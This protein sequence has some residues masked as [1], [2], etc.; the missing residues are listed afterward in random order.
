MRQI[1]RTLLT[2]VFIL[3]LGVMTIASIYLALEKKRVSE[4][5]AKDR[6]LWG[7]KNKTLKES[8]NK[9]EEGINKL[10]EELEKIT[11]DLHNANEELHNLKLGYEDLKKENASLNQKISQYSRE[12]EGLLAKV[13]QLETS[14]KSAEEARKTKEA[15]EEFWTRILR[16]KAELELRA[17]ELEE[18]LRNNRALLTRLE[19]E[20][21]GLGLR[22]NAVQQEKMN[23]EKTLGDE[24]TL[25]PASPRDTLRVR[26]DK[27]NME[28]QL[29]DLAVEKDAL[30]MRINTLRT[31]IDKT[32]SEKQRLN[33]QIEKVNEWLE[34]KLGEVN[35]VRQELETALKEAKRIALS[36]SA[37]TVQLAPIVVKKED[38][39][40]HASGKEKAEI[41]PTT[42]KIMPPQTREAAVVLVNEAHNF[43]I[44]NIGKKEGVLE[45][46]VFDIFENKQKIARVK[47]KEVRERLSA[48][49]IL[50]VVKDKKIKTENT[51]AIY[52]P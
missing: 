34:E 31:E 7:I 32:E 5:Y 43:V 6:E 40:E 2:A 37:E 41:Y 46:M 18:K 50:E 9:S 38:S 42:F 36:G 21:A 33:A 29:A 14:L 3:L 16:E 12:K 4:Q 23:I 28:K 25:K 27:E 48:A 24:K 26:L 10:K 15:Q 39:K 13:A 35:R 52:S 1:L 44:L 17:R 19:G 45:G 20:R 11:R 30:E 49:Q 22:L 8:L 51:E 47:I